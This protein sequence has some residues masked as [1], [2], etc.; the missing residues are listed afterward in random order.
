MKFK[1]QRG[2]WKRSKALKRAGDK[3]KV[4]ELKV[5][6]LKKRNETLKKRIQRRSIVASPADENGAD[7]K[8]KEVPINRN[9]KHSD[10]SNLTPKSK[11]VTELINEG[12]SPSKHQK[13]V[14]KLTFYN[15]IVQEVREK[16]SLTGVDLC[17]ALPCR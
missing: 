15:T 5:N 9:R 16:S 13:L 1:E 3:V 14:K 12:I 6:S 11:S 17:N 4:L 7:S 8:N 2:N 10:P